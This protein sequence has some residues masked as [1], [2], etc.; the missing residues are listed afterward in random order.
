MSK[1]L[2]NIGLQTKPTTITAEEYKPAYP[3]TSHSETLHWFQVAL[4][5]SALP[6]HSCT[7]PTAAG[8]AGRRHHHQPPGLCLSFLF[9]TMRPAA[10]MKYELQHE[11]FT[12]LSLMYAG[13]HI[14][15]DCRYPAL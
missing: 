1:G 13:L 9:Q 8:G 2:Y 6:I 5:T 11:H 14:Y 15:T 7:T 4:Q 10:K 12:H 3:Q